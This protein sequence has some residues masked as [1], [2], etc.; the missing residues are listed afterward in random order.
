MPRCSLFNWC[1]MDNPYD[2]PQTRLGNGKNSLRLWR[3]ILPLVVVGV[4]T[5]FFIRFAQNYP[6]I[7]HPD[8][9]IWI[10]WFVCDFPASMLVTDWATNMKSAFWATF[11]CG[12]VGALQWAL[13]ALLAQTLVLL[14]W[15]HRSWVWKIV[16]AQNADV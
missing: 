5:F 10:A 9:V 15:R 4:H 8:G 12:F 3:G 14:V 16:G 2:P 13:W 7:N 1:A 11:V 6:A